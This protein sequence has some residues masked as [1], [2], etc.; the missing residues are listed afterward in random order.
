MSASKLTI[1]LTDEQAKQI[2]DA[3][4]RSV[5][6]LSIDVASGQLTDQELGQAAGGTGNATYNQG[7]VVAT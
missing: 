7:Q 2:K 5:T 3:T 4:G 6:E 1:K